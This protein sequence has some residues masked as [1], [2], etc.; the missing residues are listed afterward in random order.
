MQANTVGSGAAQIPGAQMVKQ[1][2]QMV[3][4]S[5]DFSVVAARIVWVAEQLAENLDLQAGWK[6]LDVA[7][8]SGNGALA[9]A[10]RGCEV[11]GVDFVPA[12]L[13]R[14]RV[15]AESERLNVAFREADAEN[16]PF[17]DGSFDA[18]TSIFGAMFAPD[19]KKAASEL[20]RVCKRGGKIGL[21]CWT[22][23]GHT[24]ES[25]RLMT[26]H[27]PPP[28][29]A[30]PPAKWGEEGYLRSLFG[31]AIRSIQCTKQINVMRF[32]SP[33]TYVE[34]FRNYFGPAV[35]AFKAVGAE[36]SDALANDMADLARK[37]NRNKDANGPIAVPGTYLETV[38]VRS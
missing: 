38:I 16:L 4:A 5:G 15:R 8:G 23:E 32:T 18:V 29:S 11:T 30:V 33:D 36:G 37:F 9:A 22:P 28:P 27:M 17:A 13:E 24:A 1:R 19:H 2:S 31:D 6:V 10:R 12:L 35:Q 3:W 34:F 26:R 21:C 20:A 14:G 7:T 25:I